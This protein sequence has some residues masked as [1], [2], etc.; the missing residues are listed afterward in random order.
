MVWEV[1]PERESPQKCESY[2]FGYKSVSREEIFPPERTRKHHRPSKDYRE[3]ERCELW[4]RFDKSYWADGG[5]EAEHSKNWN[6]VVT[7]MQWKGRATL[8]AE[9]Y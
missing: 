6:R 2:K 9:I 3:D 4:L 1:P 7:G 8:N 5:C